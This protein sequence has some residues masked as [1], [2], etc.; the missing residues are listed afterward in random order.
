M[1]FCYANK[2]V[3]SDYI[4]DYS[5]NGTSPKF[6]K[7]IHDGIIQSQNVSDGRGARGKKY[8]IRI[9]NY[10]RNLIKNDS[11]NVRLGISITEN[12]NNVGFSKLRT[13]NSNFSSAPSM[14]VLSPL[15]TVLYGA[16]PVVPDGKKLK[17]K[18]YYTKPD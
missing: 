17:L 16:S 18:I 13:A 5:S 8:R 12:I 6:S 4:L 9:T 14:S 15:G 3:L 2:K 10:V 11:T 7:F 1:R